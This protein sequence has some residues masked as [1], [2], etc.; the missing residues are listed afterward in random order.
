MPMAIKETIESIID[1]LFDLEKCV[2]PP[3][4]QPLFPLNLVST[5]RVIVLQPDDQ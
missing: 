2:R 3:I 4:L 5:T 1:L